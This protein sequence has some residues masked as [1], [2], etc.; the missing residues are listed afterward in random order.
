MTT[1]NR[2]VIWY[3][4]VMT[5]AYMA[6]GAFEVVASLGAGGEWSEALLLQN[7]LMDGF[8]LLVIGSVFAFG[9]DAERRERGEGDAFV[10]VGIA[11]G[12]VFLCI[13]LILLGAN[14]LGLAVFGSEHMEGWTVMDSMRPAIYIGLVNLVGAYTWRRRLSLS[15]LSRAGV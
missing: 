14:L 9:W 15:R 12:T 2:K 4:A 11:M 3:A 13:Y 5:M 10:M 1:I 8:V 7:S 6:F